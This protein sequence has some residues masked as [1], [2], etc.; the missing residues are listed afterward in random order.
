[1]KLGLVPLNLYHQNIQTNQVL[2]WDHWESIEISRLVQL[3][4][5][6]SGS[7]S[8]LIRESQCL[9]LAQKSRVKP[10]LWDR[11]GLSLP[12][13]PH[14][15][16]S[17]FERTRGDLCTATPVQTLSLNVL[18]GLRDDSEKGFAQEALGQ[19]LGL[20]A[21]NRFMKTKDWADSK[22]WLAWETDNRL[23]GHPE[24][25]T[26]NRLLGHPERQTDNRLLCQPER[27]TD[28]RLLGR[29]EWQTDNWLL[30]QPERQ[31]DNRLLGQPERHWQQTPWP[32]WETDWQQT[33]WPAWETDW[34]QTP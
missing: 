25:Q 17:S 33:P 28:N 16:L 34:H 29:P 10:R 23:P 15:R 8:S 14:Q 20:G 21:A 12:L 3:Y 5:L 26:D 4:C 9:W 19:W 27:Q 24:R 18:G 11:E 1:M 7:F 13:D 31:T 22:T 2:A 30:G 32:V 6:T